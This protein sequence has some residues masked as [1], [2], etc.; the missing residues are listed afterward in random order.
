MRVDASFMSQFSVVT[1]HV[2][3]RLAMASMQGL[4]ARLK[5][6]TAARILINAQSGW[7]ARL[8]LRAFA[9]RGLAIWRSLFGRG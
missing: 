5:G 8:A 1:A 9:L 6:V 7:A 4:F 3:L 2:H